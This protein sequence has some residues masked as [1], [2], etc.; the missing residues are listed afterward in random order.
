MKE[1][2]IGM[3]RLHNKKPLQYSRKAVIM[4]TY[5]GKHLDTDIIILHCHWEYWSET[6]KKTNTVR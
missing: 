3:D 4:K 2:E 1:N 6:F 5:L